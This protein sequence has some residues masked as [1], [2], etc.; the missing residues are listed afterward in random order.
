MP[1]LRVVNYYQHTASPGLVR[2]MIEETGLSERD[3]ELVCQLRHNT[4][5]TEYYADMA[6]MPKK[7]YC[8]AIGNVSRRLVDELFRLAEIGYKAE[9]AA[10]S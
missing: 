9:Q 8:E 10:K 3:Q 5:N 2:H 6:C 7:L 1:S 4:G